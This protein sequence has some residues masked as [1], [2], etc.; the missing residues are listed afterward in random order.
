MVELADTALEELQGRSETLTLHDLVRIVETYHPSDRP[1]VARETL[2]AYLDALDYD[3]GEVQ[4]EL[5]AQVTDAREWA[6]TDAIYDVGAGRLSIFPASWHE[7]LGGTTDLTEYVELIQDDIDESYGET[8]EAVSEAG[9]PEQLLFRAMAAIAGV[10]RE[11]AREQ[12]STLRRQGVLE[13][14]TDQHPAGT[15]RLA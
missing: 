4:A 1:G 13:E 10:D 3:V 12:L 9:V 7:Q 8:G 11:D 14:T 5:D 15:V 6:E 2:D